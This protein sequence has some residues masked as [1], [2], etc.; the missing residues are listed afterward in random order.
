MT[1][2]TVSLTKGARASALAA[3]CLMPAAASAQGTAPNDAE[4][5]ELAPLTVSAKRFDSDAS[6]VAAAVF[7][8]DAATISAK[9]ATSVSD[10]LGELGVTL[11]SYTGNPAQ[12]TI[13]MRGYGESG[14]LNTLVLI[15]GRRI[16]APDMSGINWLNM[17]LVSI[18][19]IEV[20]RGSQSAFYGNNAGGGVIDITT[21]IPEGRGSAAIASYG[22]WNTWTARAA[23]WTALSANIRSSTEIGF[24]ES[25]GYRD[26]SAYKTRTV[27][28]SLQGRAGR[29]DWKAQAGYDDNWFMFPGPLDNTSYRDNPRQS[30]YYPMGAD[31]YSVSENYN[32]S[33]SADWKGE[34]LE[35]HADINWAHTFNPWNM[36]V[37]LGAARSLDTWKFAP[38]A[39]VRLGESLALIV[40]AD[41]EYDDLQLALFNDL[42]HKDRR[43]HSTL[44]RAT[45][46]L[47]SNL[48][49]TSGCGLT[50]DLTARAQRHS[51]RDHFADDTGAKPDDRDDTRGG[52]SAFSLGSTWQATGSLR[53]WARGD[54]FFRYPAIDEIVAYQGY[55]LSVPF[56]KDL[57]SE[58]GWGAE[59]GVDWTVPHAMFRVNAFAQKVEDLIAFD[60]LRNLN[61][62]IADAKRRGIETSAQF[63]FKHWKGGLFYTMLRVELT[64]GT[65]DGNELYLVPHNQFSGFLEWLP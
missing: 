8:V 25:D 5:Y 22:S 6:G 26:N 32:A 51:L 30:G 37:G 31:Y 29:V 36:G 28:E 62:N 19:K 63:A 18:D 3:L 20:M 46:G 23:A 17:P 21:S 48:S 65:Y 56:N 10:L 24:V 2:F 13:D 40:G 27:S 14:N 50:L 9:A 52:D 38:R 12:S 49:W 39:R 1:S 33:G 35:L 64:S 16:N 43:S 53:L 15:D 58:R 55:D 42:A 7:Q 47:Y 44:K 61:L 60:Y 34:A 57:R 41:G 45:A 54:R 4:A 59:A 11:R